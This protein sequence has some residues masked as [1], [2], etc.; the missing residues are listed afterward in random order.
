GTQWQTLP[1]FST[2]DGSPLHVSDMSSDIL[3]R[4]VDVS[5]F[6][7]IYAGAQKNA[8]PSGVTIVILERAWMESGR[9][10]I[11]SI[12]QYR[13]QAKK[14]SMFNTPPTL[15]IYMVGRVVAWLERLGGVEGIAKSNAEKAALLYDLLDADGDFYRVSVKTP[16]HRSHM[17]VTWRLPNEALDT[18]FWQSA[19]ESGLVGL[20]GHRLA[21]GIRA[22]IYNQMPLVGVET[23]VGFMH[24]F[25]RQH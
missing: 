24:R 15:A 6:K 1:D 4:P 17:N 9:R 13:V 2:A 20:K 12:W 14:D 8:G 11:P 18:A 25:R 22:S 7:C 16:S 21:G 5:R 23:L 10:D 19:A 3:S